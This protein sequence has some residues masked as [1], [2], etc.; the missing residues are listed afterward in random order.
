MAPLFPEFRFSITTDEEVLPKTN[1]DPAI[2]RS[3]PG[4]FKQQ[5]IKLVVTSQ[6][7]CDVVLILDADVMAAKEMSK[8]V[9][10]PDA[11]P[12]HKGGLAK[13]RGW[14]EASAEALGQDFGTLEPEISSMAMGVTPEFLSTEIVAGLIAELQR[15]SDGRDW[16]P[17]LMDFRRGKQRHPTEFSLYW[18]WYASRAQ[19]KIR[20]KP[21]RLY[22]WVK[23]PVLVTPEMLHGDARWLFLVLQGTK[24]SIEACDFIYD[25][26]KDD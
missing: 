23:D 7:T 15:R 16:G 12:Y 9:L 13:C 2:L 21:T 8:K 22:R 10:R 1:V 4:W 14:Y 3:V 26:F 11:I 24:C 19:S 18:V 6:S 20:H 5:L 17:Y 25:Q